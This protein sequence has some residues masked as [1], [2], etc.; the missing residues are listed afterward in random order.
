MTLSDGTRSWEPI[1]C[2]PLGEKPPR[3]RRSRADEWPEPEPPPPRRLRP[4]REPLPLPNPE[5]RLSDY[6]W[7]GKLFMR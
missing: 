1:P 6:N 3:L 7:I 5:R 4:A 2:Y